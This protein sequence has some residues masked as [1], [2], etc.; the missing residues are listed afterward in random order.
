M[1]GPRT[2]IGKNRWTLSAVT[3]LLLISVFLVSYQAKSAEPLVRL[4]TQQKE[5]F[6]NFE[7]FQSHFLI[8]LKSNQLRWNDRQSNRIEWRGSYKPFENLKFFQAINYWHDLGF[9]SSNPQLLMDIADTPSFSCG[10]KFYALKLEKSVAGFLMRGKLLNAT[11]VGSYN[12]RAM[13][14]FKAGFFFE[15]DLESKKIIASLTHEHLKTDTSDLIQRN[16]FLNLGF[17]WG[18]R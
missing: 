16:T 11:K 18:A 12:T 10:A 5:T 15:H 17:S 1:I 8:S 7:H 9:S 13:M 6:F 14:A 2:L 3:S 4:S